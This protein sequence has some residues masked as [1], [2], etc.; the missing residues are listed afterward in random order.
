M[1][2]V[3]AAIAAVCVP[4]VLVVLLMAW[5]APEMDDQGRIITG[6]AQVIAS[7]SIVPYAFTER[8]VTSPTSRPETTPI[9][10]V[11]SA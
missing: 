3:F 7:P 2:S 4:S 9:E 6:R 8:P 5:R 10:S 1:A 11:P